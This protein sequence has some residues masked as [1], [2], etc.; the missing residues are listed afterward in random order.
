MQCHW[1]WKEGKFST[2][3]CP[4]GY[5]TTNNQ[6]LE[7]SMFNPRFHALSVVWNPGLIW[8][9]PIPNHM[10]QW[11]SSW[12]TAFWDHPSFRTY[13]WQTMCYTSHTPF[14]WPLGWYYGNLS[15]GVSWLIIHSRNRPCQNAVVL[16]QI[17]PPPSFWTYS[18]AVQPW[19]RNWLRNKQYFI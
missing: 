11:N 3:L 18:S 4:D 15:W 1:R 5:K 17:F 10:I 9:L 16:L 2:W 13:F 8:K 6:G 14:E 7:M 19:F 12:G